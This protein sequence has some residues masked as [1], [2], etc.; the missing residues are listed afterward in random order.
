MKAHVRQAACKNGPTKKSDKT[1]GSWLKDSPTS[2]NGTKTVSAWKFLFVLLLSYP[3]WSI[4]HRRKDQSIWRS[5]EESSTTSEKNLLVLCG[6]KPVTTNNS[7]TNSTWMPAS[8][9]S[10]S[11][12][13][14]GECSQSWDLPSLNRTWKNGSRTSSTEKEEGSLGNTASHSHSGT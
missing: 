5:S 11:S 2:R 13:L 9:V 3:N 7:R 10:S 4:H 1:R 14:K 8:Q 12:T 6:P